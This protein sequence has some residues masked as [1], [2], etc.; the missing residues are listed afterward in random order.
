[1][2]HSPANA[3]EI[4]LHLKALLP[5]ASFGSQLVHPAYQPLLTMNYGHAMA[6]FAFAN[7]DAKQS[8]DVLYG[9]FKREFRSKRDG[10]PPDLAFV[11]CVS[12][13][14]P[15]FNEFSS[16]VETDV[17][18]CRKFVIL[19]AQPIGSSLS[20]LPFLP[21][22]PASQHGSSRPPSAQTLLHQ[23]GM[24]PLLARLLVVQQERSAQG[25]M[26]DC[27][28]GRFGTPAAFGNTRIGKPS[29]QIES[30]SK[31]V[32][33]NRVTIQNFR[34][35]RAPR[36]FE[37]GANLTV[38]YGPNGFGKTSFFDAIDFAATGSI[39]RLS[40]SRE[41]LTKVARHLDAAG[42][43]SFVELSFTADGT[44]HEIVRR[45]D[46]PNHA[47]LDD[48]PSDRKSILARLT[49]GRASTSDRIEHQIS[50]FRA[51]HLFSQERQ[52]LALDFQRDST[53]SG[54]IVSRM[55]AFDDYLNAVN[56]ATQVK[57]LFDASIAAARQDAKKLEAEI[58]HDEQALS[59]LNQ[60]A[61]AHANYEADPEVFVSRIVDE[62]RDAG[63]DVGDI[64]RPDLRHWR[65]LIEAQETRC[66]QRRDR[67]R[68]L[69]GRVG[70][71]PRLQREM[72]LSQQQIEESSRELD[73][74]RANGLEL[75]A[76][77]TEKEARLTTLL[78]E[79]V[80]S[81]EEL[82]TVAFMEG[83]LPNYL[84]LRDLLQ[85]QE[86][87]LQAALD[88]LSGTR[89]RVTPALNRLEEVRSR[90]A[91]LTRRRESVQRQIASAESFLAAVPGWRANQDR[92]DAIISEQ[93]SLRQRK[94]QLAQEESTQDSR[95]VAL[96]REE[97]GLRSE[98]AAEEAKL[99]K[100]RAL[101]SQLQEFVDSAICPLCGEDHGD[102]DRL[103][104]RIRT[105][106]VSDS[107]SDARAKLPIVIATVQEL[108]D[109]RI[110]SRND[111]HAIELRLKN[112]DELIEEIDAERDAVT[113]TASALGLKVTSKLEEEARRVISDR[114][115]ESDE[116]QRLENEALVEAGVARQAASEIETAVGECE[117]LK[118][119]AESSLEQTRQ[120]LDSL[121]E[122]PRL[123][124][125]T[126]PAGPKQVEI[127]RRQASQQADEVTAK[128]ASVES[129]I[130]R[131][132]SE[133]SVLKG[134]IEALEQR[135]EQL[136]VQRRRL[137][138]RISEA[139]TELL[140]CGLPSDSTEQALIQ[141]SVE[142]DRAQTRLAL[143]RERVG[144]AEVAIDAAT[145]SAALATQRNAIREKR[146]TLDALNLV[147]SQRLPWLEYFGRIVKRLQ[148][149]Q[150]TATEDFTISYGPRASTIQQRLRSVYGFDEIELLSRGSSIAVRV[151]R[152]GEQLRPVD[153]FSQSQQQTL[154]LGLFLAACSSQN[155]SSFS[156]VLLDDPITHFDD[157]NT[158]AF[159][160]LLAGL[161]R[162][163]LVP[164]QFV[165][166]TCDSKFLELAR[167]KFGYMGD[168]VKFYRFNS[169]G[170]DGPV[171][172]VLP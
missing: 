113:A 53:L 30:E 59:Q 8:Y 65:A 156:S 142:E 9:H 158:Y 22:A 3:D 167:Q 112:L 1:M 47:L 62:V 115:D 18:F 166:S 77:L 150:D 145:T 154:L 123:R 89:E 48:E 165:I 39:G 119:R 34:A 33:L 169:I 92:R 40:I 36:T 93:V 55:L 159:L 118:T 10:S 116:L 49:S 56:K 87:E 46:T 66:G 148:Q 73:E 100:V 85:K 120:E 109:R 63:I 14:P 44:G 43:P 29:L 6:T 84:R 157:L 162:S 141:L 75:E 5:D 153:Y 170:E 146:E 17:Y 98:I 155:W 24:S 133:L 61:L 172:E 138:A 128:V 164:H 52:E 122:N 94:E 67:L 54:D 139:A 28:H 32:R 161:L 106:T 41:Q 152:N 38:L 20:R 160:D 135:V 82:D 80:K 42:E 147:C 107:A 144:S 132:R 21:L 60:K 2:K 51:S 76:A 13:P 163:D 129:E 96:Q 11:F 64:R 111:I 95:I 78:A 7:G 140:E 102:Q 86:V 127:L 81:R 136:D 108:H 35:Y 26:E 130:R 151:T 126:F 137:Q 69:A 105:Q 23:S 68:S 72:N 88:S 45:V 37:L 124:D 121:C 101:L 99:S 74:A 15:D 114:Q 27:L 91:D 71:R 57:R 117:A 90:V 25:I 110:A 16:S 50:L 70:E 4:R 131:S 97:A 143:L 31:P 12:T 83:Q 79:R 104:Q 103:L 149:Q 19:L 125:R 168:R 171:V 134:R 58:A